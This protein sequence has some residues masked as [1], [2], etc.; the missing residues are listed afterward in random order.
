MDQNSA[1]K[2]GDTPFHHAA[3]QGHLQIADMILEHANDKNP[4]DNNGFF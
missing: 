1:D 4:R 3:Q 2:D